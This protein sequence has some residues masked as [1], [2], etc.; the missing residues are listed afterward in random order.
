[1]SILKKAAAIVGM[2]CIAMSALCSPPTAT[3]N[4]AQARKSRIAAT[5]RLT[6]GAPR[7]LAAAGM[8]GT[9]GLPGIRIPSRATLI[10]ANHS[11]ERMS[12]ALRK[13]AGGI[14][15][16]GTVLASSA[17]G[18]NPAYGVYSIPSAAGEELSLLGASTVPLAEGYDDGNGTYYSA[19]IVSDNYGYAKECHLV[20]L[21]T[22][23]WTMLY[24]EI[25]PDYS[26]YSFGSA[27]D[28]T[29][30]EV[31]SCNSNPQFNGYD[32]VKIDYPSKTV[33]I[34]QKEVPIYYAAVGCDADGQ[35]Y[36]VTEFGRFVKIDKTTGDY[37]EYPS[38]PMLPTGLSVSTQHGACVDD[39]NGRFLLATYDYYGMSASLH[40]FSLSD[41][42]YTK[43]LDFP[44]GEQVLGLYIPAKEI[45]P[46]AP[47]APSLEAV[48]DKGAMEVGITLTMPL[49]HYDGSDAAGETFDYTILAD[50]AVIKTGSGEAGAIINETIALDKTGVTHFTAILSNAYGESKKARAACFIG[51]GCPS[52]PTNVVLAWSDNTATLSWDAVSTSSDGGY[53]DPAAITYIITDSEGNTV[54]SDISGTSASFELDAPATGILNVAYKVAAVYDSKQSSFTGSN[55]VM[56]GSYN[57]PLSMTFDADTFGQHTVIDANHDGKTWMLNYGS[58]MISYNFSLA[59]DDWLISPPIAL[60]AGKTYPFKARVRAFESYSPERIEVKAGRGYTADAMTMEIVPPTVVS[61]DSYDGLEISGQIVTDEAGNYN[62][63]FHGISDPYMYNFY[64]MS[65]EV[66]TPLSGEN[67]AMISDLDIVPDKDGALSASISFT[68]PTSNVS[69]EP[70]EG[71]L[72]VVMTRDGETEVYREEADPGTPVSLTD[73][74]PAA[75]EYTYTVT[76]AKGSDVSAP[77]TATA[78]I[79]P[80]AA[81]LVSAVTA[82]QTAPDKVKLAWEPVTTDID[83]NPISASD[84]TYSVY[85]VAVN[86][87]GKLELGECIST[88]P[89]TDTSYE[90]TVP[91][92]A[93]QDYV[94]FAVKSL[95]RG[96]GAGDL[97]VGHTVF[98]DAYPT[99]HVISGKEEIQK[100]F[101]EGWTSDYYAKINLGSSA[102]GVAAQDSDDSY[103]LINT[104]YTGQ[105]ASI[106]TGRISLAGLSSPAL[107]FWVYGFESETADLNETTV[108]IICDG[109]ETELRKLMHNSLT[110][111][112]W[113]RI[114]T[115]LVDFEGK[116]IRV[117]L[118]VSCNGVQYTLY[119]H[120]YIGE[121]ILHDLSVTLAAPAKAQTG[122]EFCLNATVKNNGA[123][124]ATSYRINLLRNG[125]I[126][127]TRDIVT[128]LPSEE[129][130]TEIFRQI[131]VVYDP[132]EYVFTA[133][134][135]YAADEV[136]D[137]NTSAQIN[138]RRIPNNGPVVTNL[139]GEETSDGNIIVWDAIETGKAIPVETSESFEK[140]GSWEHEA[141]GWLF[142]DA[143]NSPVGGFTSFDIPGIAP[144]TSKASFF[145]WD[146]AELLPDTRFAPHSGNKFIASLYRSDYQASDDWAI[147]PLLHEDEQ[148]ISFYAKSYS[149]SYSE[150]IQIL[151]TSGEAA[152]LESYTA[153]PNIGGSVPDEWTEYIFTVPAGTRHFAVRSMAEGAYMLELDDFT[154][155]KDEAFYGQLMGYNVYCDH[156]RLNDQPVKET[157]FTHANP[158]TYHTY[159]VT[160][161]YDSG[162]SELSEPL[163]FTRSSVS[164]LT[165]GGICVR[166]EGRTLY[167][168]GTAGANVTVSSVDGRTIFSGQGDCR[169]D[170]SPGVC[171]VST[172]DTV[173][174]LVV[175]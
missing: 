20:A 168:T 169:V 118:A 28:P 49:T 40:S 107:I 145:V 10:N 130:V 9:T 134:V 122:S 30:G 45:N 65:Y 17:W 16:R 42:E 4:A 68:V 102:N 129:S 6:P 47:A 97:T 170:L 116:D 61:E 33:T 131:P 35:F 151:Y 91:Q 75:G 57:V 84:V 15:L 62:I 73:I 92:S 172:A 165:A 79:G 69:G 29:T 89:I 166:L 63:G 14:D 161:V 174:K 22:S 82:Y 106:A 100:Y 74:V 126:V 2:G 72:S 66:G 157:T 148:T 143:D 112:R 133:E 119:D 173:R 123:A 50:G 149:G 141:D 7:H 171:L 95:N 76:C 101:F 94:Y 175:R 58:A 162:E 120:I 24:D 27:E 90:V 77:A 142:V 41:G 48:C 125:E 51:K 153:V 98:G 46:S 19:Y 147:S 44:N 11:S 71:K 154:F 152:D 83:G 127:D 52:A 121:N 87:A 39:A 55:A 164:D 38:D 56:L 105:E 54:K 80:K 159:H 128:P 43:L 13:A 136:R 111:G 26:M 85:S 37:T 146:A 160:A 3:A 115:D 158:D 137:N 31:Y 156:N 86:S 5:D 78:Y 108:S 64:I 117:K 114:A 34:I 150:Y 25:M 53:I 144:K 99:P 155:V 124:D 1:M 113:N 18:V 81:A 59:M 36:G 163:N 60:E 96:V 132:A 32:W 103:I 104:P 109:E 23:D 167:V 138:I 88:E 140:A 12:D 139:K 135:D 110:P 93:K 21:N 70:L 67:P 8:R